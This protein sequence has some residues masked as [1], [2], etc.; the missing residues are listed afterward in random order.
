MEITLTTASASISNFVDMPLRDNW[1]VQELSWSQRRPLVKAPTK[2][3]FSGGLS[4]W[5][6][7]TLNDLQAD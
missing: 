6:S 7:S 3:T 4:V 1:S 2:I 5:S